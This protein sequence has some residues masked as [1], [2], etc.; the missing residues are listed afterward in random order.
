[1]NG[2]EGKNHRLTFDNFFNSVELMEGL[3]KKFI[4]SVGTVNTSRKYM[5]KFKS[6][7]ELKRGDYDW[8]TS[9]SGLMACKWKDK[10]C[11]HLLS[12]FRDPDH[13]IEVM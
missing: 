4:Y 13:V 5:P 10:R 7:R 1:M 9:D 3:K 6:D 8:Y 12:N 2:L 11:V